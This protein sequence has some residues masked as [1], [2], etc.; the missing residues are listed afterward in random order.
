MDLGCNMIV[1]NGDCRDTAPN[2]WHIYTN[3][4]V[5]STKFD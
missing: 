2:A 4:L 3:P 5:D 1:P